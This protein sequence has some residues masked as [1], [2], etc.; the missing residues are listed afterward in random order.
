MG[1]SIL[2]S[3][4]P[5]DGHMV[6]H[7]AKHMN[8]RQRGTH[9]GGPIFFINLS[10]LRRHTPARIFPEGRTDEGRPSMTFRGTIKALGWVRT[11]HRETNTSSLN[12]LLSGQS[13]ILSMEF[14]HVI[15]EPLINET[16]RQT[17][18][19]QW[20]WEKIIATFFS[21]QNKANGYSLTACVSVIHT[22][23]HLLTIFQYL[24]IYSALL[25]ASKQPGSVINI[26][27]ELEVSNAE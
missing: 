6:S 12:I 25:K 7:P 5:E 23:A 4:R 14:Y 19:K 3:D 11:A 16:Q 1:K 24:Q 20:C 17:H 27:R 21:G 18:P 15:K 22:M 13:I 9:S 10:R 2:H 26:W 8:Q